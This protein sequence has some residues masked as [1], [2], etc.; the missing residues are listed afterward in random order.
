[1]TADAEHDAVDQAFRSLR[2]QVDMAAVAPPADRIEA[3]GRRRRTGHVLL[4]GVTVLAVLAS[5]GWALAR[6]PD[7]DAAPNPPAISPTGPPLTGGPTPTGA[8]PARIPPGFL[9]VETR[10]EQVID[11]QDFTQAEC[12]GQPVA[13]RA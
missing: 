8:R 9:A 5:G 7:R 13:R 3:R 11:D 2:A 10:A 6:D 1:M 4:T 12:F